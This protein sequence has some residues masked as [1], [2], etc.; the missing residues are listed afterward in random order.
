MCKEILRRNS[1]KSDSYRLLNENLMIY[2]YER[3]AFLQLYK[4]FTLPIIIYLREISM[5]TLY[6]LLT[7]EELVDS[8]VFT[9]KLTNL[10]YYVLLTHWNINI[11]FL[12]YAL[13][14]YRNM[15][16]YELITSAFKIMIRS[17]QK[18]SFQTLG[19]LY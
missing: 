18:T 4:N 6:N 8:D 10:K 16:I 13:H 17:F 11:E 2:Y 3:K 9:E 1:N 19:E 5:N 12:T 7:M 15:I 14:T